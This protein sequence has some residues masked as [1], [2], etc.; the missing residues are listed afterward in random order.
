MN[1]MAK[2]IASIAALIASLAIAW[3]AVKGLT[4][5][6]GPSHNVDVWHHSAGTGQKLY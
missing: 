1:T 3:V 5:N 2:L 4:L 6:S